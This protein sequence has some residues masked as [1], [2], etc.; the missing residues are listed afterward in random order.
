M[1]VLIADDDPV[2][3]GLLEELLKQY[4]FDVV[5]VPNGLEAWEA[6]Q[7]DET[8]KLVILDWMMPEM[9]GYEVCRRIRE[10]GTRQD[11][12]V[13]LVTGSQLKDEIIKILVAGAD[14][15]IIKPFE[16]LDLKIHLR[17]AMR[18]IDLEA[19]AAELRKALPRELA[20][21]RAANARKWSPTLHLHT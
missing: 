19:E 18:I 10:A 20:D 17:A 13:I 6:I 11:T 14:D 15:Y 16:P 1:R 5:S 12:Y 4:D 7:H 3:R 9:D 21:T 2:Y 8:I